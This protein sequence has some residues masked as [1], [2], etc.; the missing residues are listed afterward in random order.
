MNGEELGRN[1]NQVPAEIAELVFDV[2]AEIS[3]LR[4]ARADKRGVEELENSLK[5]SVDSLR[6]FYDSAQEE[7]EKNFARWGVDNEGGRQHDL[8]EN[9]K[10]ALSRIAY[11]RT[12][13]RDVESELERDAWSEAKI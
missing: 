6:G 5:K 2:Q 11:L 13:I 4:R 3:D 9:L 12:L 1:N 7:L 10:A 8:L